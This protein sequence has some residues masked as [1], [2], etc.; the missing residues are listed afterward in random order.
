MDVPIKLRFIRGQGWISDSICKVTWSRYSHVE[1]VFKNGYF[2]AHLDKGVILRPFDYCKPAEEAF[3]TAMLQPAQADALR[4]FLKDQEHK[5]Y[6]LSAIF[7]IL[8]HRDWH[9]PDSWFCSELVQAAFE[10]ADYPLVR[11]DNLD[12]VTPGDLFASM[13]LELSKT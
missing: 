4:A 3:A 1:F 6:D 2:G 12:R 9:T 7:G 8:S 11:A 5:P 10:A 13:R